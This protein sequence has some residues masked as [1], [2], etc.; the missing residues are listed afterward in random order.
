M[1]AK[2]YC[3]LCSL[4][5]SHS[6]EQIYGTTCY[7]KDKICPTA[8]LLYLSSF[9]SDCELPDDILCQIQE[10]TYPEPVEGTS[11]ETITCSLSIT[12]NSLSY[13][14]VFPTITVIQWIYE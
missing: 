12:D 14:C 1:D 11:E 3:G 13:T 5:I 9:T 7:D 10:V 8:T 6:Y 4:L 2:L